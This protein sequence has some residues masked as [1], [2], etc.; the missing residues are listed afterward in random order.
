MTSRE[1]LIENYA[2]LVYN[3]KATIAQVPLTIRN[4]VAERVAEMIDAAAEQ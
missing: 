1:R 2:K 3:G 4:A